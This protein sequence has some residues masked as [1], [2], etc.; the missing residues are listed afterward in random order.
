MQYAAKDPYKPP[1]VH[2]ETWSKQVCLDT[3][4]T[5]KVLAE[6]IQAGGDER[7]KTR[8]TI[9]TVN[10]VVG[11][12]DHGYI[13]FNLWDQIGSDG[14][15]LWQDAYDSMVHA[16]ELFCQNV[17]LTDPE[18]SDD[19]DEHLSRMWERLQENDKTSNTGYAY[20]CGCNRDTIN[21]EM[22]LSQM[23]KALS[24]EERKKWKTSAELL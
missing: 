16:Y 5:K 24:K 20:F 11:T 1:T 14:Q 13:H 9:L 18:M 7:Q 15:R 12:V 8:Y 17:R 6:W 21:T 19:V 23:W 2:I 10:Q 22:N 4:Y 3:N